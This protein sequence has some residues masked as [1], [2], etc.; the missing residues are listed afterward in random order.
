M[1][2]IIDKDRCVLVFSGGQ[3]SSTLLFWAKK[4]L[5]RL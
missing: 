1:Q 5:K 2:N 3:D 4:S